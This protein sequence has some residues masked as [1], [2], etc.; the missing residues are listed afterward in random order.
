MY[1]RCYRYCLLSC[2]AA[3][4][5]CSAGVRAGVAEQLKNGKLLH[6]DNIAAAFDREG[7]V[8][9]VIVNLKPPEKTGRAQWDNLASRRA[10]RDEI[11]ERQQEVLTALSGRE[12]GVW[13]RFENQAGFS[14]FVTQKGLQD[15]ANHPLVESV[16]PVIR[17]YPQL[18]QGIPL[19]NALAA[20]S[21]YNG[22]GI[23]IAICDTGI[24]YTH[25][26]LG[27]GGFPNSK[28][29]GGY[30][31]GD[32]DDDPMPN[33]QAHGTAC[34]G[35]AA[36]NLGTVGDYIGGVAH[37]AKLY[38]LKITAGT[39]SSA[40]SAD[41]AA[42]WDWCV[43]HQYD[44]PDNPIMVISTSYGGGNHTSAC[45]TYS[46]AMTN[47]ANNAVAAGITVLAAAGND[48]YCDAISWPA[49]ISNVISVGAVFDASIGTQSF[50]VSNTSCAPNNGSSSC[51]T[52][53]FST[54]QPTA[55]DVVAVYSNTASFLDILA[56]SN[57]A[58]TTD[59]AGGGGY[60]SLDYTSTFGGTSAACPYAAGAVAILQSAAKQIFGEFLSPAQ[61]KD[62]L[63]STGNPITD[64]KVAIT[65]PRVNVGNIFAM[66]QAVP[67]VAQ[68]GIE[69]I[70][71]ST[72]T[73]LALE[74][75][76]DGRPFPPGA[77]AYTITSLPNHGVLSEP[78]GGV[79]DSVPYALAGFG[80]Q[81]VYTPKP[82]CGAPVQFSFIANDGGIPP[83][84][85]DS[86]TATV[87]IQFLVRDTIYS[88]TMDTD[89]GW[90]LDGPYWAWGTPTGGR[91]ANG[92][93][94]PISG[95]T[96]PNVVGYNL[97]GDY[98]PISGTQWATTPAI[99]C[100]GKTGVTLTFYRWLNVDRPYSFPSQRDHASIAISNNGT[101]WTQ[102][103]NNTDRVTDN[104]W[105]L[106]TFD[107][108]AIADNQP[109]VYIRWGMGPTNQ[110]QHYS[111]WNID[112]VKLTTGLRPVAYSPVP[113]DF[114]PD[115]DVDCDDL[116][117]LMS[118]WLQA[119]GD[120]QGAD[121]AGNGT[122]NLEDFA[123][124]AEYWLRVHDS[125]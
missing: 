102:I 14:A 96:G 73:T 123:L 38:A 6:P 4:T 68:N 3:L 108:S 40:S 60:S 7:E 61:I 86:N 122:V 51:S 69:S 57:A 58:Y 63:I 82:N 46:T 17:L 72:P 121:L 48:G 41:M 59:I 53:S 81:V 103:W 113:V 5:V 36:G 64:G 45:D 55:A 93:P 42:A 43:T 119:C 37:N 98:G 16:E 30:D 12:F 100:T 117:V 116:M 11:S 106:Q 39:D 78:E 80:N 115:C 90:T 97:A 9:E 67:P 56:P 20:R 105:R 85:G 75:T 49:C 1:I 28:V 47:A 15:I 21:T 35:I 111:G 18:A 114:E 76:D 32:D 2:V 23:A 19:M 33:T 71:L 79:I 107:I 118:Y 27:G 25:P 52:G 104:S 83:D 74:A 84:G 109:T 34:A 26:R 92:N 62:L 66:W 89:P 50:C 24:D 87:T 10:R 125:W 31:Y 99:D 101:T 44:D 22:Q 112:D 13:H 8:I 54:S 88:A 110:T 91:G 94:D 70:L 95:F 29:I 124:F 77:L 120:C 65:K